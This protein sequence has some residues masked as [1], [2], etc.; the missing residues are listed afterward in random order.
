[1]W[2]LN[3][4]LCV[5]RAIDDG[6]ISSTSI[7]VSPSGQFLATGSKQGVVNIYE[8]NE[9][10]RERIPKPSKIVKNLDTAITSVKFNSTCEILSMASEHKENAFRM[11]HLP[12]FN[13][14]SN[15]PTQRSTIY[16]ALAIDFSPNS[17]FLGVSNNKNCA[18]LYRLKHYGNY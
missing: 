10:L 3:S 16:N 14:F 8:T 11:V 13:V 2:D 5:H 9:I 12:S 15:F 18:H 7:A 4:R 1:M 6:C 17:G